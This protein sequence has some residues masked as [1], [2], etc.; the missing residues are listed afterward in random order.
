M[1]APAGPLALLA[2]LLAVPLPV[3]AQPPN[4][5]VVLVDDLRWDEMGAARHPYLRT[6]N[7]DR[8][9]REGAR[10]RN[11]FVTTP[12][13]S[14]SR[15]SFLTGQYAHTHGIIDNVDRSA[16]SHRLV[17]F[18]RLLQGAGYETAFIGKWHMGNDDSPRPGFDYWVSFKGQGRYLNPELTER[19]QTSTVP[20]YITDILNA[21]AVE[22][23]RRPRQK[24]FVLYLAHKAVHPNIRQ[25]DDGSLEP[26][27]GEMF[28]PAERHRQLY[29]DVTI[30][31]RPSFGKPP[32]GKPA[33][34]RRIG[35]L[36]PL[37]PAT[38][39]D[40]PTIL[41]RQRALAAVDDG[42]GSILEALKA[43]GQLENTVVVFAGDNGYFYGEHGLSEERRLAYEESARI[44]LVVWFPKA[45]RPQSAPDGLAL[46][47]DVAPTLLELAG[48][49]I[50]RDARR[51]I[52]RCHSCAARPAT[53]G[54]RFSS[55]TSR[56]GCSRGSSTWDTRPCGPTGGSTSTTPSSRAWTS[57]TTSWPTRTR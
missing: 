1:R 38:V 12:L 54:R 20:G 48:V 9:A 24:P 51:A 49:P 47:I 6:P 22:F 37:G 39:T 40:D 17:T 10:L 31:R 52:A 21:R 13:C 57:S 44:P 35:D 28:V 11:A 36:P 18:P 56:T 23:I 27:D 16:A 2:F 8:L 5:V 15:A 53:G 19:G 33:L 41:G 50:P 42:V 45:I 7:V 29:T 34:L 30:P 26:I 14:P 55:S 32:V 3:A 43:T 25:R 4:I 46:N